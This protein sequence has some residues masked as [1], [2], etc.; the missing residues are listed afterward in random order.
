MLSGCDSPMPTPKKPSNVPVDAVWSGGPDG[1]HWFDCKKK[2][3]DKF[4]YNC[5]IYN[6][7][8]GEVIAQGAF[9][10]RKSTWD[11]SKGRAT[12]S[13]TGSVVS[14]AYNYYDGQLIHLKE[15]LTLLPH[16]LIEHPF[17]DGH[18]KRQEY[19]L[20]VPVGEEKSY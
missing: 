15:S 12:Y 18:G 20:G 4:N 6:D 10:L 17:G 14:L 8:N 9:V 13:A 3:D 11:E 1:G 7:H 5:V 2:G 16:G 19:N